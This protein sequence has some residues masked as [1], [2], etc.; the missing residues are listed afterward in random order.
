MVFCSIMAH[1]RYR[2]AAVVDHTKTNGIATR[3]FKATGVAKA[4][5]L[6][7][8]QVALSAGIAESHK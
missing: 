8:L 6:T 7:I 3:C 2:Y 4:V 5:V 1:R